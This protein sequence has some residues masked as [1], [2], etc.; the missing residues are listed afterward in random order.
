MSTTNIDTMYIVLCITLALVLITAV[1]ISLRR[2]QLR[3][4]IAVRRSAATNTN[5]RTVPPI[6]ETTAVI[7]TNP[8][9]SSPDEP[10]VLGVPV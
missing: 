4:Q 8:V 3:Q 7:V 1:M 10:V 9:A 6:R 2:T 5:V